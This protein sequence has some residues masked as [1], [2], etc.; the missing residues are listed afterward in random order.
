MTVLQDNSILKY[1]IYKKDFE[2]FKIPTENSR[3]VGII[4]D[5][6]NNIIWFTESGKGKLG[7]LNIQTGNITEFSGQIPG[8]N[9]NGQ[10]EEL[11][12]EPT[13]LLLD[14]QTSNIY[15]SDHLSN[16]IFNF[17]TLLLSNFKKYQLSDN[18]SNE[19]LALGMVFD[20]YNNLVIAQHIADT[21]AVLDPATDKT[22]SFNI[23]TQNSFVQYLVTDS[24]NDIWFAEQ[25]GEALAKISTKFIPPSSPPSSS[26]PSTIQGSSETATATATATHQQK[27]SLKN[28]NNQ[29]MIMTYIN[30]FIKNIEIKFNDIFGPIIVASF[31]IVTILFVNS[32]NRLNTNIKDMEK[33]EPMSQQQQT[34]KKRKNK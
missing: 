27:I 23:P 25:K 19:G 17:N 28:N 7:R 34:R 20:K 26:N 5:E 8:S 16:S 2:T 24:N 13:A 21:V 14:N 29:T 4:Y 9:N 6:K 18:N 1:N 31:V 3:P 11:M 33:L 22:T 30:E 32:S 15:I 10:N 12:Q